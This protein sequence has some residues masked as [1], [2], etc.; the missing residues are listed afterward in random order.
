MHLLLKNRARGFI[1]MFIALTFLLQALQVK[2]EN[3]IALTAVPDETEVWKL[4]WYEEYNVSDYPAA[5]EKTELLPEKVCAVSDGAVL[6]E[7]GAFI[8]QN[9][10]IEFKFEAP[11][12]LKYQLK[13]TYNTDINDK[14]ESDGLDLACSLSIDGSIP[15]REAYELKFNRI[16]RD[17]I[18]TVGKTDAYG[19]EYAPAQQEVYGIVSGYAYDNSG[20]CNYPLEYSFKKGFHTLRL[21]FTSKAVQLVSVTLVPVEKLPLYEEIKTE[22]SKFSSAERTVIEAENVFEKSSPMIYGSCDYS[23]A[24]TSPPTTGKIKL[25]Y[26]SGDRFSSVGQWVTYKIRIESDGYYKISARYR[27]SQNEGAFC[28]KQLYIDGAM[29][30]E[31]AANWQFKYSNTWSQTE[32]SDTDGAPYLIYLE[33]GEHTITLKNTVGKL[34]DMINR[35]R[36]VTDRLNGV[37]RE[38]YRIVGS[39]VDPFRDYNFDLYLKD[40]IDE[41]KNCGTELKNVKNDFK[42]IGIDEGNFSVPISKAITT[43]ELM[44]KDTE[45]IGDRMSDFKTEIGNLSDWYIS[46]QYQKVDLD[47]IELL[48]EDG[49]PNK[50]N[51]SFLKNLCHGFKVFLNSFVTSYSTIGM[52][53]GSEG[54]NETLSVWINSGGRDQ[55]SIVKELVNGKFTPQYNIPVKVQLVSGSLMTATMAGIGPDVA[56]F[57]GTGDPINYAVRGAAE[58]LTRFSD[59]TEVCERFVNGSIEPLTYEGSVYALPETATY[60]MMFCRM[61]ILDE[62]GISPPETW[63]EVYDIMSILSVNHYIFAVGSGSQ[64]DVLSPYLMFLYQNGGTLY[65]EDNLKINID[66]Y[67]GINSF[68]KLTKFYTDYSLPI[69]FNF[70][71]RFRTGEIAIG[72]VDFSSA[73]QLE[74]FAPEIS[75][76]WKMFPVPATVS[77]GGLNRTV[78]TS[79]TANMI[80][81]SSKHKDNAWEFIKWWSSDDTQNSYAKHLET[82]MGVAARYPT[83]N[84]SAF[85]R[86]S[87]GTDSLESL[88]E[89]R[90]YAVG[91]EQVPGSYIVSRYLSFAFLSVVNEKEEPGEKIIHYSKLINDELV[92]KKAEFDDSV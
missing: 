80:L 40:E 77:D 89:Q 2:A 19:N 36:M 54:G 73:N 5:T 55:A 63:D 51:K 17:D 25:N 76:L 71:N 45:T 28:T 68:S 24:A 56:M 22:S 62:L 49:T 86:Q 67:K 23:S 47:Y 79:G 91:I 42:S 37:Y 14:A 32:F 48:P 11:E 34:S 33:S 15:F 90:K 85:D 16:W 44:T 52:P 9:E 69:E 81:S 39:T 41:L 83:A 21:K 57:V 50:A 84:I 1:G 66:N 18:S 92:R 82:V 4:P 46:L 31:E 20:F 38:I 64:D 88:K 12:N 60:P 3:A 65:D 7:N 10:Y 43:I 29:P 70:M 13:L 27:Q 35:V 75:G 78:V 53:E 59:F 87:W 61:D 26:L 74:V 8:K 72:I 30:F 6:D 58:D